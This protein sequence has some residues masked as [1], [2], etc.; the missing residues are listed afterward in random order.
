MYAAGRTTQ[1]EHT[2]EAGP[3]LGV[4]VTSS[5]GS[6]GAGTRASTL[7]RSASCRRLRPSSSVSALDVHA[8]HCNRDGKTSATSGR[9]R[10]PG[11]SCGNEDLLITES[12]VVTHE[13]FFL[14]ARCF[15]GKIICTTS[16]TPVSRHVATSMVIWNVVGIAS[17]PDATAVPAASDV[18]VASAAPRPTRRCRF[19][20]GPACGRSSVVDAGSPGLWVAGDRTVDLEWPRR[21]SNARPTA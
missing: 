12:R 9:S 19:P 4:L 8:A 5:A 17:N 10:P 2:T 13:R 20:T 1:E 11:I 15:P 3:L 18:A 6:Y 7:E 16:A 14:R 21:D